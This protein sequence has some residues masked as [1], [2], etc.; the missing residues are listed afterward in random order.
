MVFDQI[1]PIIQEGEVQGFLIT[2][3]DVDKLE[4]AIHLLQVTATT[5]N[6]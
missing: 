3:I 2:V 5:R 1:F 6:S 4:E